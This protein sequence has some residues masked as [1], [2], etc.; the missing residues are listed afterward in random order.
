MSGFTH[1]A[2]S[3]IPDP[4]ASGKF[5]VSNGAGRTAWQL[6][7]APTAYATAPTPDTEAGSPGSGTTFALGNHTHP[8][9]ALYDAHGKDDLY[10]VAASGSTLTVPDP[11]TYQ[12][13]YVLLT[14]ASVAVTMPTAVAGQRFRVA[15][16]QDGTGSR[17]PAFGAHVG[18]VPTLSTTAGVLDILDFECFDGVNWICVSSKL[19]VTVP[20]PGAS[21]VQ[22]AQITT[23]GGFT[24]LTF[25]APLTAGN[26][27]L[28]M[29]QV[30]SAPGTT[31]PPTG[32][33]CSNWTLVESV[34]SAGYCM[35]LGTGS[36]G[37]AGSDVIHYQQSAAVFAMEIAGLNANSTTAKDLVVK[38]DDHTTTSVHEK[39]QLPTAA[40]PRAGDFVG[41]MLAGADFSDLTVGDTVITPMQT[42]SA[43]QIVTYNGWSVLKPTNYQNNYSNFVFAW[44]VATVNGTDYGSVFY[45]RQGGGAGNHWGNITAYLRA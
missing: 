32:G 40:A 22:T 33:G 41:I 30:V 16:K 19:A 42:E 7:D 15:F 5:P 9:S 29:S 2:G 10:V 43:G 28:L 25:A 21:V 20:P 35:W 38:T 3:G 26:A 24:Q 36:A 8:R 13:S 34:L 44:Q 6:N 18:G 17:V 27:V 37:G 45:A 39:T 31:T 1:S 14:A 12:A 23:S 11:A 4:T